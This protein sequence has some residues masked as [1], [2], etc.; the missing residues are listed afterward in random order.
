MC[1][2]REPGA[3]FYQNQMKDRMREQM[4][5]ENSV[6]GYYSEAWVYFAYLFKSEE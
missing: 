5:Q 2:Q 1:P 3:L 4:N 6:D